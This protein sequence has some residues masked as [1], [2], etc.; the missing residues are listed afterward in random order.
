[1]P[2][3]AIGEAPG[4]VNLIGEHTDYH[5]GFV[6]PTLIPQRTRVQ[7][8]RRDDRRVRAFSTTLNTTEAYEVGHEHGGRGWLDYIQG[9]TA[10]LARAGHV[11]PGFDLEI[12]SLMRS[13]RRRRS[14]EGAACCG[15]KE[16]LARLSRGG[17]PRGSNRSQS[18]DQVSANLSKIDQPL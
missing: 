12:E 6:L 11:V 4:R 3:V 14:H 16:K 9:V 8:T 15:A 17:A 10:M 5:E 18:W 1:M 2:E 7:A 13:I